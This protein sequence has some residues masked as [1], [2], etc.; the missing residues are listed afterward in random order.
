LG[1]H[2]QGRRRRAGKWKT[3]GESHGRCKFELRFRGRL[4]ASDLGIWV[5]PRPNAIS[6]LPNNA[7][8]DRSSMRTV[9]ARGR[10]R[11]THDPGLIQSSRQGLAEKRSLAACGFLAGFQRVRIRRSRPSVISIA[12]CFRSVRRAWNRCSNLALVSAQGKF[13]IDLQVLAQVDARKTAHTHLVL[14]DD[15]EPPS[16][17]EFQLSLGQFPLRSLPEPAT[18]LVQSNPTVP[19]VSGAFQLVSEREPTGTSSRTLAVCPLGL[20]SSARS[21]AFQGTPSVTRPGSDPS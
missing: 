17:F 3:A 1:N 7:L 18:M 12:S 14:K 10:Q 5:L 9:Q 16:V 2:L 13:L 15:P 20:P 19:P 6:A 8:I 11:W 4:G 21:S